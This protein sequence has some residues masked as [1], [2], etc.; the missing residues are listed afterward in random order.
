[1]IS[2]RNC[3]DLVVY[4][5]IWASVQRFMKLK[6]KGADTKNNQN[7]KEILWHIVRKLRWLFKKKKNTV[8]LTNR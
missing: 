5:V 2:I 6:M 3:I 8:R 7:K 1:M 4:A